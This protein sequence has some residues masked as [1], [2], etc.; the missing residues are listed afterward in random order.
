MARTISIVYQGLPLIAEDVEYTPAESATLISPGVSD[1]ACW[2]SIY[3]AS[4][5]DKND[6]SEL[7][8][9]NVADE[10]VD[11]ICEQCREE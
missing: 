5:P 9:H 2:S 6:L 4:D 8:K 3:V 7:F 10:I 11:L 1:D